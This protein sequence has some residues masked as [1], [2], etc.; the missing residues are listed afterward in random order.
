MLDKNIFDLISSYVVF[1]H[2]I[3]SQEWSRCYCE[4]CGDGRRQKGPRGGWHFEGDFASYHCFN[5]GI[6]GSFSS[7]REFPISKDMYKILDSFGVPKKEYLAVAYS[8]KINSEKNDV[9]FKIPEKKFIPIK[10]F[11]IPSHFYKLDEASLDN[12]MAN[13]AKRKLID[14]Y[15]LTAS[16]YPFYMSTGVADSGENKASIKNLVNRIIIPYFKNGKMIY[17]QARAIDDTTL[18]KY[19]NMDVPKTNIVFNA[20]VLFKDID[21][22]LYVFES[23]F[24][25]IHVNGVAVMENNMTSNQIEVLNKSPR[26]KVIV[27]DR[28]GDSKKLVELGLEEGWGLALPEIGSGNKDLCEG[29]LKFGKMFIL[30]SL[31]NRTYYG[32]EARLMSKIV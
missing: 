32:R 21:R 25:A 15:G 1:P 12:P 22:P 18:P 28:G 29:I 24:D 2:G 7:E 20:D 8:R 17:Y 5:C 30:Y 10:F 31:V 19:L 14:D 26:K 23:A 4:V 16:S 9:E 27:P 6:K 13:Q 11:D 3:S